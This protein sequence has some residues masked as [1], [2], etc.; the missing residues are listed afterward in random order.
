M[1]NF[2]QPLAIGIILDIS[3]RNYSKGQRH[4]DIIKAILIDV[5][6]KVTPISRVYLSCHQDLLLSCG[7]SVAAIANYKEPEDFEA[8][9]AIKMAVHATGSQDIDKKLII[10]VTDRYDSSREYRYK[11]GFLVN[12]GKEYGCKFFF[13]GVGDKYDKKSFLE[14]SSPECQT[15][16]F[17][18][19]NGMT[20]EISR[21]LEI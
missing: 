3:I 14:L 11:K 5:I 17:D 13:F 21:I 19:I 8:A 15:F 12:S 18:E 4:I 2:D 10:L 20:I 6:R 7:E 1:S 9:N 16:H